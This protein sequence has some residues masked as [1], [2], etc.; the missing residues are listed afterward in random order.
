M[1]RT[2]LIN[3]IIRNNNYKSYLEI[4][5]NT[6]AQPG[7][8]WNNTEVELKH[9]VDPN[10]QVH[11]TYPVTSDEFFAKHI[12]R[13]YDLIFVDGLHIFEQVYKDIINSLKWLNENGTIVVHDCNPIKEITQRRVRASDVWHGDVWKAILKLRMEN[14]NIEIYTVNTDEGCAII[15]KGK[16]ELF[17]IENNQ[18]DIY[19][20]DFFDANRKSI[21]NLISVNE[22]KKKING[23]IIIK[24]QGGLGNQF[25][26]YALGRSLAITTNQ[27]VKYD[28][29]WFKTQNKRRY[30]LGI[31]N[32]VENFATDA[33]VKQLS[34]YREKIGFLKFLNRF[35]PI[36]ESIYITESQFNFNPKILD[37]KIP[38]YLDGYWQSEKYFEKI[39]D[40]IHKE[41]V[42]RNTPLI[43]NSQFA[44]EIRTS[45]SVSLHIRRTDYING[46]DGFYH[47]C[48]I[49]YYH[50]ALAILEKTHKNL[51]LFVFSDDINW[52]KANLKTSHP[53]V[54]I[55][56]NKGYED[57][58]LMSL[59][60]QNVIA[61][62]TFSW[63]G[64][65]LNANPKKIVIAPNKWFTNQNINTQDL[66]PAG[67]IKI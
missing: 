20:F 31:Y 27:T 50:Q 6:P 56:G 17:K 49:D 33:E 45:N 26:Q 34:K 59:C 61:N 2:Q 41:L 65:W 44:D 3:T 24:F 58:T 13:K 36:D 1:T 30:E 55:D 60:K 10:P 5:V 47:T 9:G 4:G 43:M 18:S 39:K 19:N 63:W 7:Y 8:N 46:S 25:F 51:K 53:T 21:L 32:V 40:A 57:L 23:A 15:K 29:S 66:I 38:V 16:Q 35:S 62:S 64:A 67:W 12:N 48:P 28:L 42:L 37:T 52:V 22:F 14:P 11:A 54:F